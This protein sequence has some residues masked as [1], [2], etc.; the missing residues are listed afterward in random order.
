MLAHTFCTQVSLWDVRAKRGG[1]LARS[2]L[3][4]YVTLHTMALCSCRPHL[5]AI[6]G[7]QR[8]VSVLDL[9]TLKQIERAHMSRTD[10]TWVDFCVGE[11]E[12]CMAAGLDQE[13]G[14]SSWELPKGTVC[15]LFKQLCE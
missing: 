1:A 7:T 6:A 9:R 4:S 5:L 13:V 15:F 12:Q 3:P 8:G 2:F 14:I 11:P 10:I